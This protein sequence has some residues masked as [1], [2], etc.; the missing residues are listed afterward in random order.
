MASRQVDGAF[1]EPLIALTQQC[2]GDLQKVMGAFFS[3]LHR[4]TDFYL[5]PHEDDI[6]EGK[7]KMGFKQGDA[8]KLLMAS[9]RQFP[10]RR[11][12]RQAQQQPPPPKQAQITANVPTDD[13]DAPKIVEESKTAPDTN[14]S[15]NENNLS[16]KTSKSSDNEDSVRLTEEGLQ[17]PVGNGGTAKRYKWTQTLDECT[18]LI[19]VPDELRGKDLKVMIKSSSISVQSK[20]P[21]AGESEPTFFVDGNLT[22]SIVP[23]ESTW[24]LEGG[25]IIMILYKKAKTFWENVIEG[26][27]KIDA[28]LVDS[29]RHIG[30]YDEST[31]AQI[32][33]IM[34]EQQ[35]EAKLGMPNAQQIANAKPLIPENFPPGVEYIDEKKM[36]EVTA[37]K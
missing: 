19:G 35:K 15:S 30:D 8:E 29:R 28:S 4:R 1:D 24:T 22:G 10:L 11:M 17:I 25:V 32:R 14:P 20:Q 33:K 37:K 23:D 2:N 21:L 5:V 13:A 18:V 9:F 6:K 31:Q 26:D 12:P 36:A 7:A 27:E 16:K 3:F 34:F